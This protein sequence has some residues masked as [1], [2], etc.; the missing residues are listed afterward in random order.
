MKAVDSCEESGVQ[1]YFMGSQPEIRISASL[2]NAHLQT[3]QNRELY[4][5]IFEQVPGGQRS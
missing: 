4:E 2:P 1:V 5:I 3:I